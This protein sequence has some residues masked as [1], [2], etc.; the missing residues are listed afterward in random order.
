MP[1]PSTSFS[2]P[3]LLSALAAG[4]LLLSGCGGGQPEAELDTVPPPA[5]ADP[6]E[7]AAVAQ[8]SGFTPLPSSD[9]VLAAIPIGRSDPFAAN[10][11]ASPATPTS[12]GAGSPAPLRPAPLQLPPDFRFSGVIRSAGTPQALV[13]LGAISG[14]V[15]IGE[16]GGRNTDLLP[17]GW[18]VSSID[19]ERGRLVL[20]QGSQTVT[21]EL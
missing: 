17:A 7:V 15:G 18:V 12:G 20:R 2:R 19:V 4:F 9:Q 6:A 21:A 16:L 13:Q 11:P 5:D 3:F 1:F 14:S 10:R 8:V